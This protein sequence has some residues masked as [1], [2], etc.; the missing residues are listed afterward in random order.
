MAV[1]SCVMPVADAADSEITTIE[2]IGE[3]AEGAR[4]QQAWLDLDVVQCGYFLRRSDLSGLLPL[5]GQEGRE[6][7]EG[8]GRLQ[9]YLR[10]VGWACKSVPPMM[11]SGR[12]RFWHAGAASGEESIPSF[13]PDAV[14]G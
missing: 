7:E 9:S 5:V 4:V 12:L 3:T 13:A 11:E 14:G 6:D 8:G 2:A 10:P 1:R